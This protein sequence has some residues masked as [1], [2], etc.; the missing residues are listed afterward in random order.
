MKYT[1]SLLLLY[2][3]LSSL[4]AQELSIQRF[5]QKGNQIY[6]Y[7]TLSGAP[8]EASYTLN[9]KVYSEHMEKFLRTDSKNFSGLGPLTGNGSR[10]II[11]N[12]LGDLNNLD[13][14]V[15]FHLEMKLTLPPKPKP[16]TDDKHFT[17][18]R[19]GQ[20]YKTVR[21]GDQVWMAQNLNYP[22]GEYVIEK[23]AWNRL[24][25]DSP[26]WCYYNNEESN[27]E[28][29]GVLY[30]WTAALKACPTG[31]HLPTKE[32]FETLLANYGGSGRAAAT[33]LKEG[34]SSGFSALWGGERNSGGAFGYGGSYG[35]W[36]SS[37]EDG[38]SSWSL[39]MYDGNAYMYY[40]GRSWGFSVRCLQDH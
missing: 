35:N 5:E 19:D 4:F 11:W 7:Y 30:T 18:P 10:T 38:T 28:K 40:Y 17:D 25:S 37:S 6:I 24:S 27:R 8:D 9:V 39:S 14:M 26:A 15:Q 1:L 29:Y 36:W 23:S 33:A 32:E 34:G 31:W 20:V 12:M 3:S 2:F 13:D 22:V 16:I 21:I